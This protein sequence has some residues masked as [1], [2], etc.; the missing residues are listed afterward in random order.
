[1]TREEILKLEPGPELDRLVC[2]LFEAEPDPLPDE[3]D[4]LGHMLS[5]K[6][7]QSPGGWWVAVCKYEE[8]DVPKW[9]PKPVSTD[10]KAAWEVVEDRRRWGWTWKMTGITGHWHV[11]LYDEEF[12]F[13]AEARAAEVTVAICRAVLL[14]LEACR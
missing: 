6:P 7:I 14:A 4:V 11:A 1:M 10:I 12:N 13:L 8:G 2:S 5:G 3:W 9:A